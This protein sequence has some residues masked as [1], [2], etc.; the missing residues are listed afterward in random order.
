MVRP[1]LMVA[2]ICRRKSSGLWGISEYPCGLM[3]IPRT[4][5]HFSGKRVSQARH[6]KSVIQ[7]PRD[8]L[9]KSSRNVGAFG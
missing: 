1:F 3:H 9:A 8:F 4:T 5:D 2:H 6:R 7:L